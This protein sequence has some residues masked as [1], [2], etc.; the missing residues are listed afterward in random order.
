MRSGEFIADAVLGAFDMDSDDD[1][2]RNRMLQI[3]A[4]GGV[5]TDNIFDMNP[6]SS[7]E[8]ESGSDSHE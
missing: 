8:D 3:M 1:R 4:L 5:F 2:H 7:D 6:Q